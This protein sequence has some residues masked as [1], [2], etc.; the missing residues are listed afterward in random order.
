MTKPGSGW[1]ISGTMFYFL[2]FSS[3]TVIRGEAWY[4]R[5]F[6]RKKNFFV[7]TKTVCFLC[8]NTKIDAN[9]KMKIT[10]FIVLPNQLLL[11]TTCWWLVQSVVC[12]DPIFNWRWS[13]M[14][15]ETWVQIF[16]L[17]YPFKG[18]F[19][20]ICTRS[21]KCDKKWHDDSGMTV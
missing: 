20:D 15:I 21:W 9:I 13:L 2:F 8:S 7:L 19:L 17:F 18:C 6:R 10:F 16:M 3:H 14:C 5:G 1:I 4:Y 11:W 12:E